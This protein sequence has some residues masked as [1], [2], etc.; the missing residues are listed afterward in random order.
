ML[1]TGNAV[2]F[3]G[4]ELGQHPRCWERPAIVRGFDHAAEHP[5]AVPRL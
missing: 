4:T 3:A 5:T 2:H 1:D